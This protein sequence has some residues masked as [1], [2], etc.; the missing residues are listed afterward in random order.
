MCWLVPAVRYFISLFD[1]LAL[2]SRRLFDGRLTALETLDWIP[3][4]MLVSDELRACC[5][6]SL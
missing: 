1:D 2:G 6:D 5:I 3:Y 4:V